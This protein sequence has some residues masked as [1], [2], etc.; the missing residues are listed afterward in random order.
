MPLRDSG[1]GRGKSPGIYLLLDFIKNSNYKNLH[2]RK[3][4]KF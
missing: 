4:N 1:A 2:R 3:F